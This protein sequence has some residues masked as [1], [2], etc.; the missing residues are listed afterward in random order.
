MKV[1]A[2]ITAYNCGRFIG[3]AVDSALAQDYAGPL[4][5]LVIDDG[6]TDG[7]AAELA[8]R[9][10]VRVIRQA[11]AGYVGA[12]E[13]GVAEAGGELIAL[14]DGDDAWPADKLSRQVEALGN[15]GLV[16]GDM[17]VIDA[18]G[19]IIDDSWLGDAQPP[20]T[21]ADWLR[22]NAATSSSILLR[23]E[24]ARRWCPLPRGIGFVDW[25]FAIRAAQESEVVYLPEPRTLYRFHG[26]NMSLGSSG[27]RRADQ[28][29]AALVFQRHFLR[30]SDD[31]QAW[32]AFEAFAL[33][34]QRAAET[35]FTRIIPVT[36]RDREVARE[37][38]G[39]GAPVRALAAD[40]WF[41]EARE[42]L[43]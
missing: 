33:E 25:Y 37:E 26:E 24:L 16:Y 43:A 4:E 42:A 8:E 14:L 3:E 38:L 5:V 20:H 6:S 12:T 13:R 40:P 11:N 21:L 18:D 1:T 30:H 41:R 36:A 17:T 34:L 35:P 39:R 19:R 28:L 22:G 23:T 29:R 15:A 10:D 32:W 9:P 7:T 2:L 27:N 31:A